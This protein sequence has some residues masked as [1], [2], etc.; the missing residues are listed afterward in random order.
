MSEII[1]KDIKNTKDPY[2]EGKDLPIEIGGG[3]GPEP[4]R[5]GLESPEWEV[6][7]RV[8]DF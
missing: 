3:K 8:S 5:Y 1:K 4:T 7:G 6:K 2:N